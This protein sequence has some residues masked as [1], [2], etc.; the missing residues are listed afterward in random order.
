[1]VTV[2]RVVVT[3]CN[4]PENIPLDVRIV[5]AHGKAPDR[6]NPQWLP[7]MLLVA[8]EWNFRVPINLPLTATLDRL[9]EHVMSQPYPE[10]DKE[11][12]LEWSVEVEVLEQ[13]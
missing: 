4:G 13:L 8:L 3:W 6:I 5:D 9:I 7:H 1:M 12:L 2:R 11:D 10:D